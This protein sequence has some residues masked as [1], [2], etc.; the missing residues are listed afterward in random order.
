M[1]SGWSP[2]SRYTG[3]RL[4]RLE[5][6]LKEQLLN[7]LQCYFCVLNFV[8]LFLGASASKFM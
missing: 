8:R 3:Q 5:L 4:M 2:P 6:S 7:D 1:D